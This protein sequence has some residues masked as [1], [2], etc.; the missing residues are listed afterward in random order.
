MRA[1]SGSR[2]STSGISTRPVPSRRGR[3]LVPDSLE[4]TSTADD[5]VSSAFS[6]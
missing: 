4:D 3:L 1:N 5:V 2:T 6:T